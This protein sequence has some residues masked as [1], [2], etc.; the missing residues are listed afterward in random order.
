MANIVFGFFVFLL[1]L[2]TFAGILLTGAPWVAGNVTLAVLMA[3]MYGI[4][5]GAYIIAKA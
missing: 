4:W 2:V 1:S 3:C 5:L